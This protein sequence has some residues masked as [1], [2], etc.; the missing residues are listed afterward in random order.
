[1]S[2]R[3]EQDAKTS[4]FEEKEE[5]DSKVKA[6]DL[7]TNADSVM[8]HWQ[9]SQ[10]FMRMARRSKDRGV[11]T[12][13]LQAE[14]RIIRELYDFLSKTQIKEQKSESNI[15]ESPLLKDKPIELS[16]L[17]ETFPRTALSIY[18]LKRTWKVM[19]LCD[20]CK[21]HVDLSELKILDLCEMHHETVA[22]HCAPDLAETLS[23]PTSIIGAYRKIALIRSVNGNN[24]TN[25]FLFSLCMQDDPSYNMSGLDGFLNE[26]KLKVPS[27]FESVALAVRK[28]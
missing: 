13:F 21:K 1:L 25:E 16:R 4:D 2:S 19:L 26:G 11:K 3:E 9:V 20:A 28:E 17:V 14:Q 12:A 18:S 24:G 27:G 8:S 6:I 23:E 7:M 10:A 22:I 5:P 15:L